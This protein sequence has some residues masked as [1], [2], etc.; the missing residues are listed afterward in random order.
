MRPKWSRLAAFLDDSEVDL[1]AHIDFPIP[2]RTKICNANPFEK[3]YVGAKRRTDG[4]GIFLNKIAMIRLIGAVLL[5]AKDE[6]QTQ[7]H[8]M[9]TDAM[10]ELTPPT[11][12]ADI[13]Q[14]TVA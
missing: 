13:P 12:D 11:L 8:D 4:A 14:I 9:Q 7:K 10:A 2:Q 3:L 5:E 6:W 1:L